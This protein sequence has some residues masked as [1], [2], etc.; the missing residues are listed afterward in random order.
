MDKKL[1][2]KL[3]VKLLIFA[4]GIHNGI[5]DKKLMNETTDAIL[6]LIRSAGYV[7][8]ADDQAPPEIPINVMEHDS[9]KRTQQDMLTPHKEGERMVAYRKVIL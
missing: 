3:E 6:D 4:A 8:L 9:C 7:Q 1:I 5:I 2:N